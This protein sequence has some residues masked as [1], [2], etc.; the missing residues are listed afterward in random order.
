MPDP[1]AELSAVVDG[2]LGH[3]SVERG[4]ARNTVEAYA[5]DLAGFA[6]FLEEV[7]VTNLADLRRE[8]ISGF[9]RALD[10]RGQS[11]PSRTRA[12]VAV[13]RL[14]LYA[15]TEKLL[16]HD[17]MDGIES[18]KRRSKLP[19][20]LK[21]E[22]TEALLEAVDTGTPLGLRDRAMLEVL[23]G[24]GLRVSELVGLSLSALDSRAGLL[25]VTGKGGKERVVPLGGAAL[26]AIAAYLAEG[27][28]ALQGTHREETHALFV[29]RRGR[30]MTR[31]NFFVLI[32]KLALRAGI[33]RERVSPHVLRH[34]FATDLLEGGADLRSIQSMLGHSDLSTT[35]IYTHV[36][37]GRLR[38]TVEE[39]HPRGGGKSR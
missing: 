20:V 21:P 18:P 29:T 8:H 32:R 33:S 30:S 24:A 36:S 9:V 6:S 28:D 13:R 16:A 19:R 34:A 31:Q 37:R 17:P 25:R 38:K 15:Q 7:G 23:Y 1:D 5:R 3:T 2:F 39:R 10:A 35:Q 11:A 4:L 14:L 26:A 27:R 12:L 22:E